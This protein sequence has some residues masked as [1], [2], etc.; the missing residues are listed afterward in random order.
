MTIAADRASS[1]A[2]FCPGA[3]RCRAAAALVGAAALA[4]AAAACG[5]GPDQ[6]AAGFSESDAGRASGPVAGTSFR[7][8][9]DAG[10][11]RVTFLYVPAAGFAYRDDEGRVTGVTADLLRDFGWHVAGTHAIELEAAWL[12]EP[13]WS[14]FYARVRDSDGG[15]LGVGNVTITEARREEL[16]F[17]PP[18]L[19]NIAVLVTHERVPELDAM[20]RIGT[21]FAAQTALP[22]P[23]TLHEARLDAIRERWFPD[24]RTQPAASNDEIIALVASDGAYFGYVDVYNYWRARQAGLPIRRHPVGDDATE[25][26]GVILPHGSDW[27]PVIRA[28]FEADGG[29]T[30]SGRYR[31]LLRRHLGDELAALLA[32]D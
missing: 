26:F 1:T 21:A 27:T 17:S 32:G 3:E 19:H 18:Y 24:M 31:E 12:E 22:Y 8:A 23:G 25:S 10:R 15:V 6:A 4:L 20:E 7:D 30:N 16:D 14:D 11:G 13:A 28:F 9:R 29:Y 5:P 2:R